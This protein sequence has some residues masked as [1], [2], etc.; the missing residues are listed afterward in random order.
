M[1][2]ENNFSCNLLYTFD[3]WDLNNGMCALANEL[4]KDSTKD[5]EN[6]TDIL[7]YYKYGREEGNVEFIKQLAIFLSHYYNDDIKGDTL[8][9]TYGATYGFMLAMSHFLETNDYL[10]VEDLTFG[11]V[12]GQAKEYGL[13]IESVTCD[14]EGINIAELE[15]RIIKCRKTSTHSNNERKPF[16]GIIFLMTVLHNPKG[17]SY[18]EERCK[19]VIKLAR[20][21]NLL[22]VVD[23]VYN[24]FQFNENKV[25]RM[26]TFDNPSDPDY[27]IGHVISNGSFSK[28]LFPA[29][30]LGWM[31]TSST[32]LRQQILKRC[33]I[34][35]AGGYNPYNQMIITSMLSSPNIKTFIHQVKAIYK[36]Q[37]DFTF[38][39][40]KE[41]LPKNVEFNHPQGSFFLWMK[42]PCSYTATE[43]NSRCKK[44]GLKIMEGNFFS[45]SK[46]ATAYTNY[47][48]VCVSNFRDLKQ[49]ETALKVFCGVVTTYL[50]Q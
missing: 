18:S 3:I 11:G 50:Q 12:T 44:H 32:W 41:N 23:D 4:V 19:A 1:A 31:E 46:D 24:I 36:E 26:V 42:L 2:D 38:N 7:Q 37:L 29:I 39:Y 33:D 17:T 40:L 35:S 15:E 25:K 9:P 49:L 20:K 14:R 43:L 21:Y 45:S 6:S 28:I 47:F 13:Q 34:E 22:V 5:I 8:L 27:G 48:R 10:F 30:R 16:W